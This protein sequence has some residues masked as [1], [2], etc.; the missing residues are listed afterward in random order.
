MAFVSCQKDISIAQEESTIVFHSTRP[1]LYLDSKTV[2][3]GEKIQWADKDAIRMAYMVGGNWQNAT[4]NV[5]DGGKAKFYASKSTTLSDDSMTAEFEI[6][7]SFTGES[8]GLHNFFALYPSAAYGSSNTDVNPTQVPVVLPSEQTCSWVDATSVLSF[9]SSADL[10]YGVSVG[11]YNTRPTSVDISWQRIV[12]HAYITLNDLNGVTDGEILSSVSLTANDE[13]ALS[14]TY[15]MNLEDGSLTPSEI[16]NKIVVDGKNLQ[17]S[18]G[19]VVFWACMM[20]CTWKSLTVVVDTDKATYT[21]EI[22]LTG[23]EKTFLQNRRNLLTIDMSSATREAKAVSTAYYEKVTSAPADWS[24]TYL[25]VFD[26]NQVHSTVDGKDFNADCAVTI[27]DDKIASTDAVDKFAVVL[28]KNGSGYNILLPSGKYLKVSSSSTIYSESTVANYLSFVSSNT[29]NGHVRIS[30]DVNFDDSSY[31]LYHQSSYFRCYKG[32][33]T[34]NAY[35]LPDMYKLVENEGGGATEPEE[36]GTEGTHYVKVTSKPTDWSGDYLI[37]C[38]AGGVAFN[39]SLTDLDVVG[40]TVNVAIAGGKIE[41]TDAMK[42]RQF[43]IDANGYVK[44]ASGYYIGQTS[45]ANG[46]ESNET[47]TYENT[48]SFN[49][50]GTVNMV[51]GGAYLRYNSASNQNRF[52]YFKSS[53][54]TGQKA[55]TLYKLQ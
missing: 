6:S 8:E 25:I 31:I 16:T 1:Q 40:N 9:D 18:E 55:I 15:K 11:E 35:K 44:S 26:D 5:S 22:D 2:W 19:D 10:M 51:S 37:V 12:A 39:G 23:N 32:K 50:D 28:T 53:T 42:A 7:A 4:G 21:R 54:Y 41:A 49:G 46:L 52:R 33:L 48:L 17:I 29:Q 45:D 20:P 38:D 34:N 43:T 47:K 36:P 27:A 14:G 3:N 13:A 24:G 30:N